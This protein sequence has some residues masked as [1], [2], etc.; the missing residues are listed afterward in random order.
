MQIKSIVT[1]ELDTTNFKQYSILKT[2]HEALAQYPFE[3]GEKELII[4]KPE[5][6][7]EYTGDLILTCHVLYNLVKNALR[8]IR[9]AGKEKITIELE[10]GKNFNQLIFRDTATGIP[11]KFL[12][13]MFKL[14]ESHMTKHGGT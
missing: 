6:D 5:N 3:L 7:F 2:I 4:L 8:A 13:N 9:I 11:K 10:S 14:F 1:G 12:P